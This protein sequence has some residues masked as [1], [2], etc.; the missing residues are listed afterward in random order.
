MEGWVPIEILTTN[1]HPM[2][3]TTLHIG[4]ISVICPIRLPIL[5]PHAYYHMIVIPQIPQ[6]PFYVISIHYMYK[7]YLLY[8]GC[9]TI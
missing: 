3:H 2:F 7:L 6:I 5:C 8:R 1:V 4:S 9:V